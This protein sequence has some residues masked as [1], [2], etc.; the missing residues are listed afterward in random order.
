[1][2]LMLILK[3]HLM[4]T[5]SISLNTGFVPESMNPYYEELMVSEYVWLVDSSNVV[6]PVNLKDSS[7]TY[8]TGLNDKL[9]NYT[10]NFEKSFNLVNN[11]R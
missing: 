5:E 7:F 10:M 11:I 3:K 6:Y 9:I 4:L 2:I 1:M 8:K